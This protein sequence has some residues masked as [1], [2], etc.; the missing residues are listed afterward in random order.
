MSKDK[1]VKKPEP[2]ARV[3]L[4]HPG[5]EVE[6]IMH[7]TV[8][9]N[10][11]VEGAI[12]AMRVEVMEPTAGLSIP[13]MQ[14]VRPVSRAIMKAS[15]FSKLDLTRILVPYIKEV[16]DAVGREAGMETLLEILL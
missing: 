16:M 10:G 13:I 4:S 2:Y 11:H 7:V 14:Q 5:N 9:D 6:E 15:P 1:E 12:P 3:T 8:Y